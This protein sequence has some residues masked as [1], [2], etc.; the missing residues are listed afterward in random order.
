ME[1]FFGKKK[2]EAMIVVKGE[3]RGFSA[4]ANKNTL[5]S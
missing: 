3:G 1:Y 2:V 5:L 4:L